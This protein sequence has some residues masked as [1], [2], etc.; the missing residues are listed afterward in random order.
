MQ[1]RQKKQE[2]LGKLQEYYQRKKIEM[3]MGL[4]A[5]SAEQLKKYWDK[6]RADAD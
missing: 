1:E 5:A 3:P 4:N 2:R 6:L